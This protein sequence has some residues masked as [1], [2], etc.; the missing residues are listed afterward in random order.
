[1]LSFLRIAV[2]PL[3]AVLCAGSAQALP[4]SAL[5][6]SAPSGGRQSADTL[7]QLQPG[8]FVPGH[9][10]WHFG[11][12][13]VT[14][15]FRGAPVDVTHYGR[16]SYPSDGSG[17]LLPPAASTSAAGGFPLVVF[18]HGR[19]FLDGVWQT[20]HLQAGYLMDRLASHGIVATSVNLGVIGSYQ[21]GIEQRGQ[22]MLETL[23]RTLD[24]ANQPGTAPAGLAGAI[25]PTR[26]GFMGHSRGG[27]G[28]VAAAIEALHGL[29]GLPILAV[30]TI[31]P[32]DFEQL[33]L[34]PDLPFMGLYGSKDGDVDNGWPIYLHDRALSQ[35]RS[36]EYIHGANHFWFTESI[37]CSCENQADIS[38]ELHH[39]IAMGYL[40]GFMAR[41]LAPVPESSAVFADGPE[42]APVTGQATILPLYRDPDRFQLDD[43][44][45]GSDP[46]RTSS[47][48]S[49]VHRAFAF[50]FEASLDQ[51][52]YTYYHGTTGAVAGWNQRE[53]TWFAAT[54]PDF[55]ATRWEFLSIQFAQRIDAHLNPVGL[56]QDLS[57]GLIDMDGDLAT[58]PLSAYGDI[59]YPPS[60]QG[61]FFQTFPKKSVLRT[62]RLPLAAFVEANPR[63]DLDRLKFAGWI[64]DRTAS[65]EV[66]FDRVEF[67]R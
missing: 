27:E 40:A 62:T 28:A 8:P 47:G 29:D 15:P 3:V 5:S 7:P 41:R 23:V 12:V 26:L 52:P 65:G 63:L 25:D 46:W 61:S 58:V 1:M 13:Q 20:N 38:R 53:G 18:G 56:S 11:T 51:V 21:S 67:T 24:L 14:D 31:A 9:Y 43:F 45:A 35:D 57:I 64:A 39:E 66:A 30:G 44:E 34:P 4:A 22:I 33:Q 6:G 42:M 50:L 55:D 2:V 32:T 49:A 54:P 37:T 17:G 10:D 60:H 36:F 16:I 19:Y 59:P 48:T